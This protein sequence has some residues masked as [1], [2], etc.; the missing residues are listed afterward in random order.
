M[1]GGGY[2]RRFGE[3]EPRRRTSST[4]HGG[5]PSE[6]WLLG[7]TAFSAVA[8]ACGCNGEHVKAQK[9]KW[10]IVVGRGAVYSG[11]HEIVARGTRAIAEFAGA[12]SS[13]RA[14]G[15]VMGEG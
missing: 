12:D 6:E 3:A 9:M 14:E 13:E 5:A 1:G 10:I 11:V 15:A 7:A 2:E 8:A 4:W